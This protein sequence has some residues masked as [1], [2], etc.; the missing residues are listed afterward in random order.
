MAA[1]KELDKLAPYGEGNQ[2][3]VFT[4]RGLQIESMR[5]VGSDGKHLKMK[6]RKGDISL[7]VI[8]FG[9]GHLYNQLAYDK[10][11]DIAY[12]LEANL[13]EGFERVQLG[14]VD[15]KGGEQNS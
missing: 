11:Y 1:V 8:G 12:N 10:T 6:V 13:W 5:Q 4:S 2:P 7:E 9:F 14:L 3:P 15:I